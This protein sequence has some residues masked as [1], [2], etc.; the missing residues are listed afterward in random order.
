M[1]SQYIIN[2]LVNGLCQGFIYALVALGVAVIIGIVG[3]ATFTHG[4]VVMVGA[5]TAFYVFT[6]AGNHL[7]LGL[8]ASFATTWVLGM[9]IY[10]VCYEHFLDAPEHISLLCTIGFSMLLKNLATIVF[11][12]EKKPMLDIINNK[13]YHFGPIQVTKVQLVIMATV[14]IICLILVLVFT[15]TNL[16]IRLKAVSQ[17]REA[18]ALVGINVKTTAMVGNC[19]GCAMA[20]I[21]GTLIGIYYQ[22]AYATM[23]SILSVKGFTSATLGGLT[24]VPLSA[25]G[26]VLIGIMENLGIAFTSASYRDIFSFGFLI[27]MLIFKPSGFAKKRGGARA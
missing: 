27:I 10:K 9:V 3:F 15:K 7:V 6:S 1:T 19:I 21:A 24:D 13:I 11:G 2:Q 22:S 17:N 26:G 18:A 25:L 4:E 14:L 8:L 20:G 16:G 5:Y 23:G 12:V